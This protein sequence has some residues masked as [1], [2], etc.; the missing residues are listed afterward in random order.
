MSFIDLK[1]VM[2]H[3]FKEGALQP[4][5]KL[6]PEMSRYGLK[7][8]PMQSEVELEGVSIL[9]IGELCGKFNACQNT[10]GKPPA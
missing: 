3:G 2:E 10:P 8:A 5:D 4:G 9:C 6:C 1:K 7:T